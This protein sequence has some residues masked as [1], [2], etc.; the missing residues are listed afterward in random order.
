MKA[1]DL[2][3]AWAVAYAIGFAA[4]VLGAEIRGNRNSPADIDARARALA[5]QAMETVREKLNTVKR[6]HN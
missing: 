2:A 6:G 3:Q 4:T 5:D 1:E